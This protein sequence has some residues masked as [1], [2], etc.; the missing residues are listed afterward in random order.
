MLITVVK[1]KCYGHKGD[2]SLQFIRLLSHTG[3]FR[4]VDLHVTVNIGANFVFQY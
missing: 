4:L 1:Y 3:Y 2:R